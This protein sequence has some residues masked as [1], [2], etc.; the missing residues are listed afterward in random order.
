[1]EELAEKP[2]SVFRQHSEMAQCSCSHGELSISVRT[3]IKTL[4]LCF[5]F[6]Q[7][8]IYSLKHKLH[9]LQIF[10]GFD[11]AV[12]PAL[13]TVPDTKEAVD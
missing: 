2:G 5:L 10:V 8:F 6:S 13:R 1:M 4:S 9:K 3:E 11:L 12:S 7:S